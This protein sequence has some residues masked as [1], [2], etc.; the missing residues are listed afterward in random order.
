[1]SLDQGK[2]N[3]RI[4]FDAKRAYQNYTG[5]GN[6]SRDLL[7]GVLEMAPEHDYFLYAPKITNHPSV[8]FVGQYNNVTVATP[9]TQLDKTFKGLWRSINLEKT[10]TS[11]SIDI[12]HGLSNEIPRIGNGSTIKYVVTIH[13]LIFKRYPRHYKAIDRKIYNTKFKYA[14]K[15]SNRIIAIS[16][17][18]K[19]DITEF[20]GI[21]SEKIDVIYQTCHEN[22]KKVYS[23]EIKQHIKE[24]FHLP[25][26]FILNVGTIETRKNLYGIIQATL[27]M[28]NDLPIVV[29]GKKTKYFNF[30]KV[31]MQK[32][33]I[34]EKRLIFLKN[35]SVE[36]LPA[37]YQ[38]ASV[39]VYPSFFEG[40]GIPI[41]E[42]LNSET[43]VITSNG[44]C[45]A[46]AAG[47]NSKFIDPDDP[48]E[49][50]EAIDLILEDSSLRQNM[51][52][53]GKKYA[54]RFE[55][56]ILTSQLLN[57]YNSL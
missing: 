56:E 40:F 30:L 28:K 41:I 22:F 20:Y 48:E 21:R 15:N 5:L 19:R 8:K 52:T 7:K 39:F 6:Y 53:E 36:E 27:S 24:K 25:S 51:I 44:G 11:D 57:V 54:A 32:L 47:P 18:T 35:V 49:I 13:D 1:M 10:L 12:F 17:Q 16:E 38:M 4:G 45:F 37:I 3:M 31:Q 9:Q 2:N 42:A 34:D 50:G 43:P 26:E 46:E 29:I 23:D 33:N 14:C 55:P